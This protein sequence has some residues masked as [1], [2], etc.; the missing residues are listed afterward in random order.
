M[1]FKQENGL[2]PH[3]GLFLALNGP[4]L[5]HNIYFSKIGLRH[6]SSFIMGYDHAKNQKYLMAGSM[7]ILRCGQTDGQTEGRS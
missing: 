1:H 7:R 3:F 5:A 6:F 2:K 4:F